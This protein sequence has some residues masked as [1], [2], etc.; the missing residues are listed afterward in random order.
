MAYVITGAT[1]QLGRLVVQ[2][3]LDRGVPADEI[4]A[5]G[6]DLGRIEALADR[7]VRTVRIDYA[8]P[9]TLQA[10][11]GSGDIVLLISGT[12]VGLRVAQHQAV[13]DAAIRGGAARLIY[14]SAPA[15]DDTTLVLAPEHAATERA[16][17][18]SGLTYT[19]LRNGWYTENY[20]PQLQQ[21]ARTGELVA[22]VGDGRVASASRTDYA[23]AAAVVMIT[24]GHDNVIYELSGDA[25]WDFTELAAAFSEILGRP[26]VYRAI[27]PEEHTT[28]LLAAGLD[29]GTAGFV[30]ALDGNTAE[31]LLAHTP[32]ELSK[33][34]G[35]PTTPLID[36]LK[37]AYQ[38]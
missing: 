20:L 2:H 21:A 14:T 30:V 29:E 27:T 8:D 1:G 16:I 11:I 33:L 36:G 28:Q 26:V 9:S 13:I 3:L 10:A 32:G 34:I 19:I 12:E 5:G 22:S 25:A 15:A 24:E 23:E 35:H 38:A 17:K 4:V 7:G 31:G 6:R 37:G 18:A